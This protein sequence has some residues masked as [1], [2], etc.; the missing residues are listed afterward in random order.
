MPDGSSLADQLVDQRIDPHRIAQDMETT[1]MRWA[2]AQ[3]AANLLD[4]TWDSVK[5][6]LILSMRTRSPGDKAMSWEE[7]KLQAQVSDEWQNHVYAMVEARHLANVGRVQYDALKAK[8][9]A[10][11]TA[12]ATRRAELQNLG[13]L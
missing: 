12:E 9:E 13:R 3:K 6:D 10:L 7:A 5:A 4:K 2:D 1:G 11:R 8:F